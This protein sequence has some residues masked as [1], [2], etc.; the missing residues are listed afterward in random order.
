MQYNI[1]KAWHHLQQ[2]TVIPTLL[3]RSVCFGSVR[4]LTMKGLY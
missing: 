1:I 3:I 4:V 2:Y